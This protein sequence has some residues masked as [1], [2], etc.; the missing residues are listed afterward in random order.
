MVY[1]LVWQTAPGEP[2]AMAGGE[3]GANQKRSLG[4]D[5]V[6]GIYTIMWKL[7]SSQPI[8]MTTLLIPDIDYIIFLPFGVIMV[9]KKQSESVIEGL[10]I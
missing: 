8:V 10:E 4:H 9:D 2:V 5:Y 3:L 1:I 6:P 7:L